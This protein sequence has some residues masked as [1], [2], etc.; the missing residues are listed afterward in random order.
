[1]CVD[2]VFITDL[3]LNFN[4]A[5]YV[6][7]AAGKSVIVKRGPIGRRYLKGWFLIDFPASFPIEPI[8][9][10]FMDG[11][12]A[13]G[14]SM[15]LR[16]PKLLRM[17]RLLRLVRLL[18]VMK[19]QAVLNRLQ[20]DLEINPAIIKLVKL[21]IVMLMLGHIGGCLF[22]FIAFNEGN[23]PSN[24][25]SQDGLCR[26]ATAT[27]K[28]PNPGPFNWTATYVVASGS[29]SCNDDITAHYIAALYWCMATFTT[30][31]YGDI[32]AYTDDERLYGIFAMFI[33]VSIFAYIVSSISTLA[34]QM[35]GRD[36][37]S[38]RKMNELNTFVRNHHVP[39]ELKGKMRRYMEMY[40]DQSAAFETFTVIE[41]LS[42]PL[43]REVSTFLNQ[44]SVRDIP[45]FRGASTELVAF[46][47][48]KLKPMRVP[49]H[50]YIVKQGKE[51]LSM[52]IIRMG[53]V[54]VL[55]T[56]ASGEEIIVSRQQSGE[57]FGEVALVQAGSLRATGVRALTE[58]MLYTLSKSDFDVAMQA[59]PEGQAALR[60]AILF[61]TDE[62]K[63]AEGAQTASGSEAIKPEFGDKKTESQML[64]EIATLLADIQK[65]QREMREDVNEMR[66]DIDALR[67]AQ[68]ADADA[69]EPA[70]A[71]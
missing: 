31:G 53:C 58:C 70:A 8:A 39:K 15:A 7:S 30:V 69:G 45:F 61:K 25:T 1:M 48:G 50:R 59:F 6:S 13:E 23:T 33:G 21:G 19:L 63:V 20:D 26:R 47:C 40:L 65:A 3:I 55:K 46:L 16:L 54:E 60:D 43:Q 34:T 67:T 29:D 44:E 24:W 57:F 41:D 68:E 10:W 51:D 62:D 18:K 38:M 14:G 52:Y 71:P 27:P 36:A 22:Y 35:N 2:I 17:F 42:K 37:K 5:V 64:G 49:K 11:D 56:T 32:S 28:N 66:N 9:K 12:E 4:T